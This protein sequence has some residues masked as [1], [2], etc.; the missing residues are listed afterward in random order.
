MNKKKGV[1]LEKNNK[2]I[3]T[4]FWFS[5]SYWNLAY[6]IHLTASI[7]QIYGVNSY[8]IAGERME[9]GDK[10]YHFHSHSGHMNISSFLK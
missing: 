10:P 7:S 2:A 8:F 4:R 1:S 9:K 5:F 3:K 6:K